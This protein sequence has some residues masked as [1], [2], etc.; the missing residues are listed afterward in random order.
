[1]FALLQNFIKQLETD[2]L[3]SLKKLPKKRQAQMRWRRNRFIAKMFCET[4]SKKLCW[5]HRLIANIANKKLS[6]KLCWNHRLIANIANKKNKTRVIEVIDKSIK[7]WKYFY[8]KTYYSV[9][10]K[11]LSF[12]FFNTSGR[13]SLSTSNNFVFVCFS[14]CL[15]MVR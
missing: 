2:H 10:T 3:K 11:A 1:M 8:I 9:S 4:F 14:T 12:T 15:I 13:T 6:K 7:V 5:N